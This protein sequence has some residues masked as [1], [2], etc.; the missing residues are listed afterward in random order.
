VA[1]PSLRDAA[2]V[3]GL[4]P[5][6]D[7]IF[8]DTEIEGYVPTPDGPR[9]NVQYYQ[10][11]STNYFKAL[12]IRLTEGRLFDQ[13]DGNE[14]PP[15]VIVNQ[16]MART[17]W[18]ERSPI[19]RRVRPGFNGPWLTVV[20]V[21]ADVKNQGLDRPA[22]TELYF[23][24]NQIMM[25]NDRVFRNLNVVAR[26]SGNIGPV[27]AAFQ[28][29]VRQLDPTVPVVRGRTLNEV[30]WATQ[31]RPRFLASLLTG[32]SA[33]ALLLAA[34][35]IYG[36]ISYSVAQRTREFGVRMALGAGPSHV[37]AIVLR[38][39]LMLTGIALLIGLVAAFGLTRSLSTMLFE[40]PASDPITFIFVSL[41]LALVALLACFVPARRAANVN[42]MQALRYE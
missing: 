2:F 39:G 37:L 18:G 16:T 33:A 14:S 13:R 17:F 25:N 22:G 29:E 6:H 26:Y 38:R 1:H 20:G 10:I 24:F 42:P 27:L 36:V 11:V 28:Q 31:A 12:G 41:I 30:V 34:I 3:S 40:V 8:N 35:G 7:A 23:P 9:H 21:I 4:P 19:G 5:Q 15:V 32:F